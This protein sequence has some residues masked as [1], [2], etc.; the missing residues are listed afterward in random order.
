MCREGVY[1]RMDE[2]KAKCVT[3]TCASKTIWS[4][5]G[6]VGDHI[7]C[8]RCGRLPQFPHMCTCHNGNGQWELIQ[9]PRDTID[10]TCD[11]LTYAH[12]DNAVHFADLDGDGR[13]DWIWMNDEGALSWWRNTGD[14]P[15]HYDRAGL[16][17]WGP[18][19]LAAGGV[20]ARGDQ[21][22]LADMDGDGRADYVWISA[23]GRATIWWNRCYD[24]GK[25][26]WKITWWPQAGEYLAPGIGDGRGV[27]LAD[28]NGDGKADFIHLDERDASMTLYMNLGRRDGNG[29]WMFEPWGKVA[30]GVH[31][32]ASEFPILLRS[33]S[34]PRNPRP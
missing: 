26:D 11:R 25:P 31:G 4:Q 12:Y 17:H 16:V 5:I 33:C 6:P 18:Q 3:G 10:Q 23:E 9:N 15:N 7:T 28:V 32:D 8:S 20:G 21:I 30:L 1:D 27:R 2:C 22:I 13:D 14:P 34:L 29:L 24:A 19:G